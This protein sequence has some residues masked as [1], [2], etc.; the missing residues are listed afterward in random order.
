MVSAHHGTEE[1]ICRLVETYSD[2]LL[3]LAATRLS[4]TADDAD[5]LLRAVRALPEKY[6]AVVYLHYYEGHTMKEIGKF[7][8][9]PAATV[10][11]RLRRGRE[12]LERFAGEEVCYAVYAC[13]GIG[14]PSTAEFSMAEDGA[15]TLN[16]GVDGAIFTVEP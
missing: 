6:G 5:A 15:I 16:D 8:G 13:T 4:S 3:R 7:L 12:R 2:M 14:V 9:L 1:T 10:G 11:T